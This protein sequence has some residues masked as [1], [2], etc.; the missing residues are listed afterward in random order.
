M[1]APQTFIHPPPLPAQSTPRQLALT[2]API[3]P[4]SHPVP[5]TR[6]RAPVRHTPSKVKL[7]GKPLTPHQGQDRVFGEFRCK[8]CSRSWFSGNSWANC[9]QD[10]QGCGALVYPHRQV[11]VPL[12]ISVS[13]F[14]V[15]LTSLAAEQM[16]GRLTCP[17]CQSRR[18]LY[19]S[20][21]DHTCCA[22]HGIDSMVLKHCR[23]QQ[24][25]VGLAVP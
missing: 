10:C 19:K 18:A 4:S 23:T 7:P 25:S 12:E 11:T 8:C 6:S 1:R 15:L 24:N 2:S 9:G 13:G 16:L 22:C 14:V 17:P 3:H 5:A 21:S 20:H